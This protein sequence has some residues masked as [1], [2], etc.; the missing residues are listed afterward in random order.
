MITDIPENTIF[1]REPV[2]PPLPPEAI[3]FFKLLL[4][5]FGKQYRLDNEMTQTELID[6]MEGLR[7]RD[8]IKIYQSEEGFSVQL[9][10]TGATEAFFRKL[11]EPK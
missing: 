10:P 3:K 1:E 5:E 9:T 6:S 11:K 4:L 8:L 7:R 2:E